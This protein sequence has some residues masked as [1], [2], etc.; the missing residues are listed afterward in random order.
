MTILGGRTHD[1][2]TLTPAISP[3]RIERIRRLNRDRL[4]ERSSVEF[5]AR[6]NTRPATSR[7]RSIMPSAVRS[8]TT[9]ASPRTTRST[10]GYR[11]P[12]SRPTGGALEAAP[13]TRPVENR[14]TLTARPRRPARARSRRRGACR[15]ARAMLPRPAVLGIAAEHRRLREARLRLDRARARRFFAGDRERRRRGVVEVERRREAA[16]GR[17]SAV[18]RSRG[19]RRGISRYTDCQHFDAPR[20]SPRSRLHEPRRRDAAGAFGAPC[21]SP[22]R[23]RASL[24]LARISS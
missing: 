3:I 7:S 14:L 20:S 1:L 9:S 6:G 15:R 19:R 8:P 16:R 22:A 18:R 2:V 12:P 24:I 10:P 17:S 23:A 11:R 5:D 21:G 13:E 4:R